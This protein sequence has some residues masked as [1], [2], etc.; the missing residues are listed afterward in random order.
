MQGNVLRRS[1]LWAVIV[2]F[3]FG[4]GLTATAACWYVK[5]LLSCPDQITVNGHSCE[6]AGGNQKQLAEAPNP[7]SGKTERFYHFQCDYVCQKPNGDVYPWE[8]YGGWSPDPNSASCVG[9]GGGSG[10]S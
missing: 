4:A 2:V 8:G 6:W 9:G 10:G 3:G 5:R 7:V 1:R